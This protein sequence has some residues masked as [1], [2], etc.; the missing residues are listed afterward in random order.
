MTDV[1][2][3]RSEPIFWIDNS[4]PNCGYPSPNKI[5]VPDVLDGVIRSLCCST[6]DPNEDIIQ[7]DY[8]W[9]FHVDKEGRQSILDALRVADDRDKLLGY[10]EKLNSYLGL[11]CEVKKR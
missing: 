9:E 4:C 7:C 5:Y 2:D 10:L 3:R 8:Q 6:A 11:T 1:K